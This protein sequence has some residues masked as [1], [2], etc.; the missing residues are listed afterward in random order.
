MT[1]PDFDPLRPA[2]GRPVPAADE[3]DRS[4][5]R[6]ASSAAIRL[7][8][9]LGNQAVARLLRDAK[10][11]PAPA[12][13]AP[14]HGKALGS[15]LETRIAAVARDARASREGIAQAIRD[16]IGTVDKINEDLEAIAE[17]YQSAY[18]GFTRALEEGEARLKEVERMSEL[19]LGIAVSV[20]VGLG[21][22]ELMAGVHELTVM[23]EALIEVGHKVADWGI[24]QGIASVGA[25]AASGE[26]ATRKFVEN[27][28]P[29]IR[30]L[31][32]FKKLATLYRSLAELADKVNQAAQVS[33]WCAQLAPDAREL[34][35]TGKVRDVTPAALS[36][37]VALVERAGAD[38]KDIQASA[39]KL[40]EEI[41]AVAHGAART[42][43]ETNEGTMSRELW[44]RWM[45][46]LPPDDAELT[47]ADPIESRLEYWGIE[48]R[49]ANDPWG[50]SSIGWYVGDWH[51]KADSREGVRRAK[52]Y[53]EALDLVGEIGLVRDFDTYY[54]VDG[55]FWGY[56]DVWKGTEPKRSYLIKVISTDRPQNS[57]V[58]IITAVEARGDD[59]P[60]LIGRPRR[61][62]TTG[63]GPEDIA[64]NARNRARL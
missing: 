56:V 44:V 47:D 25:P 43:A 57:D 35:L 4:P 15:S 61:D 16:G 59:K 51:S 53:V 14:L 6:Q 40:G 34:S 55:G 31:A 41:A 36:E 8:R 28:H 58:V 1:G 60:V 20:S 2:R 12:K 30:R 54:P 29:A 32:S 52:I 33:D 9:T 22:G 49:A 62:V 19:V 24:E 18:E 26:A 42:R 46:S 27:A 13:P 39:R 63:A 23:S 48:G 5:S 37:R 3:G 50:Q 21:I 7:Q 38:Q 10:A 17:V 45:A 11:K 64:A